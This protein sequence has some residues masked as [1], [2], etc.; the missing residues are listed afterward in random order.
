MFSSESKVPRTCTPRAWPLLGHLP[1][2]YK[3][4]L[5]F[6]DHCAESTLPVI[7]LQVGEPTILLREPADIG[8]VLQEAASSVAKSPLI[9]GEQGRQIFGQGVLTSSGD[10]HRRLRA[11][12]QQVFSRASAMKFAPAVVESV[13]QITT[14]WKNGEVLNLGA[15]MPEIAEAVASRLLFGTGYLRRSAELNRAF[16]TRREYLQFRFSFPFSWAAWVPVPLRFRYQSAMR[17]I[18]DYVQ[19]RI[20]DARRQPDSSCLLELMAATSLTDAELLDE[21]IA[22]GITG[23]EP[24]G[25]SLIWTMW[26][27]ACHPEVQAKLH[28]EAVQY[29]RHGI[30]D[31]TPLP[32]TWAVLQESM[33]LYP[34]TWL[35]LRYATAPVTL[36]SGAS[37]PT[38]TKLYLSPWIIHRDSRFY[39]EPLRFRPERFLDAAE[40]QRPRFAYFPFGAGVRMCLG[41]HF[42]EL[43]GT[44]ILAS[45]IGDFDV[46]L[47]SAGPVRPKPRITLQAANP[48]RVRVERRC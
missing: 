35:F 6:L 45:L 17:T 8:Y 23:Y 25:E 34:P 19:A 38:G 32:Y 15:V 28:A 18:R 10:R 33:R 44:L 1:A 4:K 29:S 27:I 48:V 16:R 11:A 22:L 30:P 24:V 7:Q 14:S 41:T 36:P 40:N 26:L 9:S 46:S 20:A 21:G 42:T 43:E 39:E 37:V 3:D 47:V 2:F 12:L 31:A 13:K 5:A